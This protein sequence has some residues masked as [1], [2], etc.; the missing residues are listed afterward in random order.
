MIEDGSSN[1]TLVRLLRISRN[2][3]ITVAE[4]LKDIEK[5]NEEI[6]KTLREEEMGNRKATSNKK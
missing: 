3:N 2:L 6:K 4:L 1:P 5:A